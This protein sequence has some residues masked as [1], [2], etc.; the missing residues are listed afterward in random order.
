[1]ENLVKGIYLWGT[2]G[3][4]KTQFLYLFY[5][6]LQ[7]QEKLFIHFNKFMLDIHRSNFKH[8]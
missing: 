2:P 8:K 1:M 4:G 5:D 3:T 7:I 6:S